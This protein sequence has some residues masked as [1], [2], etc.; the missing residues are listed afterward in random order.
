MSRLKVL[1]AAF[2]PYE[3]VPTLGASIPA[4]NESLSLLND[5]VH[6]PR[7]SFLLEIFYYFHSGDVGY[8]VRTNILV[9]VALWR[10]SSKQRSEQS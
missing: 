8:F 9:V 5:F 4:V 7:L 2:T 3:H 10:L 6:Q 1:L